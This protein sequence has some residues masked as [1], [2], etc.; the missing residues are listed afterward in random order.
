[1]GHGRAAVTSPPPCVIV[2]VP[3]QPGPDPPFAL[4]EV[5]ASWG[6]RP[7]VWFMYRNGT[8]VSQ[9]RTSRWGPMFFLDQIMSCPRQSTENFLDVPK[10]N[11]TVVPQE[12]CLTNPDGI[13]Y[14]LLLGKSDSPPVSHPGGGLA[15]A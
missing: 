13:H 9:S 14:A 15:L 1:M 7:Q 12:I 11:H 10:S 5:G 2:F 8:S 6:M 4:T 3:S